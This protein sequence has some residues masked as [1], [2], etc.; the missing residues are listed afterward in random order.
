MARQQF[1]LW[2]G[3]G[4]YISIGLYDEIKSMKDTYVQLNPEAADDV[5][6]TP[7]VNCPCCGTAWATEMDMASCG[8]HDYLGDE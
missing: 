7:A 6:I 2:E 5:S 1:V 3:N 8:C 4:N